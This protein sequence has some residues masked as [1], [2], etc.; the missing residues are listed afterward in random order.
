M[1]DNRGSFTKIFHRDFFK[2]LN[3]NLELGEEFYSISSKNVFRGM[4]FQI[5][6]KAVDKIVTCIKGNITD[7]VVDLRKDSPTFKKHLSFE[8]DGD[9][10]KAI[11]IPKGLAHGFYVNSDEAI[12]HYKCSDVYDPACDT[13]IAYT[14][15]DFAKEIKT[16]IISDKDLN[17]IKLEDFSNP[18]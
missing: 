2:N 7:Y 6:P 11:F 16:P 9:Q 3:I 1:K 5:P 14:S 4:H 17:L 8:L 13:G 10:P 18:F 12:V 15:F